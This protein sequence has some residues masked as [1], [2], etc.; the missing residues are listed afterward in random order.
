M[1]NIDFDDP[2]V[3]NITKN[4]L[5]ISS[6]LG[7]K[8]WLEYKNNPNSF[9]LQDEILKLIIGTISIET[10]LGYEVSS[11]KKNIIDMATP[12][13]LLSSSTLKFRELQKL[14]KKNWSDLPHDAKS[15]LNKFLGDFRDEFQARYSGINDYS[16]SIGPSNEKL[17]YKIRSV[18]HI[19]TAKYKSIDLEK[20]KYNLNDM[21]ENMP[22][23]MRN[24][25]YNY[26]KN[27][28][29][30]LNSGKSKKI[31]IT[32]LQGAPG[33]GKT[34]FCKSL[35]KLLDIPIF[36][37]NIPKLKQ[38]ELSG[39]TR[40]FHEPSSQLLI[41]K[42]LAYASK[43]N[44][45][46][47]VILYFKNY[48][49]YGND[50]SIPNISRWL[51]SLY[52]DKGAVIDEPFLFLN[53]IDVSQVIII[54][55]GNRKSLS[56]NSTIITNS[57]TL[58]FTDLET[59][60]KASIITKIFKTKLKKNNLEF[61]EKSKIVLKKII[62]TN[63]EPGIGISKNKI[64][65]YIQS[66]LSTVNNEL[67]EIQD[68]ADKFDL[69]MF[70]SDDIQEL[71]EIVYHDIQHREQKQQEKLEELYDK[72]LSLH[73]KEDIIDK[74]RHEIE[75]RDIA[76]I[77]YRTIKIHKDDVADKVNN[78]IASYPKSLQNQIL[79]YTQSL[80][81]MVNNPRENTRSLY[82]I[83]LQGAPGV[84]KT[85]FVENIARILKIPLYKVMATKLNKTDLNVTTKPIN[86]EKNEQDYDILTK[87]IIFAGKHGHP[88]VI[89]FIDEIDKAF[90]RENK[91]DLKSSL[92][93]WLLKNL[94][95][96]MTKFFSKSLGIEIVKVKIFIITAGNDHFP[97]QCKALKSRV[98]TFNF[99]DM[100][101][102]CK[103]KLA[104]A[105]AISA[106]EKQGLDINAETQ[107]EIDDL[108]KKDPN[109][110]FRKLDG[111]IHEFARFKAKEK[112]FSEW[113]FKPTEFNSN[114]VLN[115]DDT[116][117]DTICPEAEETQEETALSFVPKAEFTFDKTINI[118]GFK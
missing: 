9:K 106:F 31:P 82:P 7:I 50:D 49:T 113:G 116:P 96:A 65:L 78:L 115:I 27:L 80:I 37:V 30:N 40:Y 108:I 22:T 58:K 99:P 64:N 42:A 33:I 11:L 81:Y 72:Y 15:A 63:K 12:N 43:K 2:R 74:K 67:W 111:V 55:S 103:N 89:L 51:E 97:S 1:F 44:H 87:S 14:I 112:Y 18:I 101:I 8:A 5:V 70:E 66:I 79:E 47:S 90:N 75:I 95:P 53:N 46:K 17:E 26:I 85:Y 6:L 98:I 56:N 104:N 21:L 32:Y 35:A 109:P 71:Q 52:N 29:F 3:K 48:E 13:A 88:Y 45:S 86:I 84:G 102:T 77:Q 117:I 38:E 41:S 25:V 76:S 61:N 60:L 100:D 93:G 39:E 36:K 94:E 57:T 19:A 107:K 73:R 23:Q 92:E 20:I 54:I 91:Y 110:G 24:E 62:E 28:C 83:Y 69:N 118:L 16:R 114:A 34:H 105:S 10:F 59:E 4:L 68:T